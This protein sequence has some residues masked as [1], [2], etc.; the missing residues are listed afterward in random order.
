MSYLVIRTKG[1]E[2][3]GEIEIIGM[4][5]GV[6]TII[7]ATI[8]IS[9]IKEINFEESITMK[10]EEEKEDKIDLIEEIMKRAVGIEIVTDKIEIE[11][12]KE[13]IA[14][15]EEVVEEVLVLIEI[16]MIEMVVFKITKRSTLKSRK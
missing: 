2:I 13:E 9:T 11:I 1:E 7:E 16:E 15:G 5:I 8:G 3:G 4:K 6:E 14:M 12:R 10:G